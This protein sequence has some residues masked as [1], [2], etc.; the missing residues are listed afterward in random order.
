MWHNSSC[1]VE[2]SSWDRGHRRKLLWSSPSLLSAART[3]WRFCFFSNSS[4]PLR[5]FQNIHDNNPHQHLTSYPFYV[6]DDKRNCH[7]LVIK[8]VYLASHRVR[9][10]TARNCIAINAPPRTLSSYPT[11]F[12]FNNN[13]W[14]T[15]KIMKIQNNNEGDFDNLFWSIAKNTQPILQ[16]YSP[17]LPRTIPNLLPTSPAQVSFRKCWDD[18]GWGQGGRGDALK[19]I[20]QI[21]INVFSNFIIF[22]VFLWN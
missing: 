17:D 5:R 22:L 14:E 20:I 7:A 12:R 15:K 19:Q 2:P 3:R 6:V 18:Y 11:I 1:A 9:R 13:T 4:T 10:T 8:P 16:Q 21:L